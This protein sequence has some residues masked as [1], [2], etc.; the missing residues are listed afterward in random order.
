MTAQLIAQLV[1]VLGPSAFKFIGDLVAV[2]KKPE[3]T[4]EE[5][6]ALCAPAQKSYED[7]IAGARAKG[8]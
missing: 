1:V 7:Y 5:V 8:V 6:L 3:L 2:W 4:A